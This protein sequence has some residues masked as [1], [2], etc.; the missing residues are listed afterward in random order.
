MACAEALRNLNNL[1]KGQTNINTPFPNSDYENKQL[2]R[3]WR[4]ERNLWLCLFAFSMWSVLAAF[5]RELGCRLKLEE[6]LVH[7]EMS[8][9]T[10]TAD[11]T[12]RGPSVSREVTSK[13]ERSPRS[14]SETPTKPPPKPTGDGTAVSKARLPTPPVPSPAVAEVELIE[15]DRFVK[16]DL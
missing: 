8:G 5:L 14:P 6:R 4:A 7:F 3:R 1:N 10:M 13:K 2:S 16:K 11:E 9:Y 15:V 12:T